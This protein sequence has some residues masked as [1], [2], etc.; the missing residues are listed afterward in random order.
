MENV[1]IL[2]EYRMSILVLP[3]II[4]FN[5]INTDQGVNMMANE[6]ALPKYR[7]RNCS[8]CLKLTRNFWKYSYSV[9]A[10]SRAAVVWWQ[11]ATSWNRHAACAWRRA[12][13]AE[14]VWMQW[15][16][17]SANSQAKAGL[18]Q[19]R[20]GPAPVAFNLFTLVSLLLLQRC[21][22]RQPLNVLRDRN[23]FVQ[24]VY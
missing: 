11:V 20:S 6:H 10:V 24:N 14:L 15:A 18:A 16:V 3:Y 5:I 22:H 17:M 21:R 8:G 1:R 23:W 9:P 2:S 13:S 7:R 19:L 4:S 12:T